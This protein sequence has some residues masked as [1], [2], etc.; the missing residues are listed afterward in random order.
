MDITE[1][2]GVTRIGYK[3]QGWYTKKSGGKKIK[4]T[5]EMP[6]KN[7]TCYAHWKRK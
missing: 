1:A 6:I 3:F 4:S 5:T 7:V 2:S